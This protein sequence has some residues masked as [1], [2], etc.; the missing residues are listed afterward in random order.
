MAQT[1]NWKIGLFLAIACIFITVAFYAYQVT[2][3]ANLQVD[4]EDTFLYIP[5][6]A[7]YQTVMDSLKQRKIIQD[8]LSFSFLAK[9][10]KYQE[11]VKAGRY[12]IRKNMGNLA[13]IRM[14][15]AGLQDPV[16][17]TF[18]NIRLKEELPGK[19]CK[20]LE[21]DSVAFAAL[22]SDPKFV[23][24]WG[25]DT[26]SI[27]TMF[28]PNTYQFYWNTSAEEVL[29]RLHKEYKKFWTDERKAKAK[30]IGFSPVQVT[31]LASI[32]E[33]ETNKNDEKQRMAGT[34]INRLTA[35][36]TNR[37]LQADPTLKFALKDFGIKRILNVHKDVESP[38]NTYKYPG[39]PPG[40]INLPSIPSI[41][42]VLN[43]EKNNYLYFCAKEDFSGH[44]NF[45]VTYKDHLANAR[46]YQAALDKRKI[47]K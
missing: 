35:E 24:K 45:A 14:L 26:V 33:A 2:Q 3:T 9:L 5:S 34:Y 43:Y 25:F 23:S 6:G 41:D 32:I 47:M 17:V 10:L 36:E 21:A 16:K 18:N 12:R 22:I 8:E 38:Y 1:K 44:H 7:V 39:L 42:A 27:T 11:R 46:L 28:L 15:R 30:A 19:I 40:P 31:V 37:R 20:N 4:K 13:A 29:E